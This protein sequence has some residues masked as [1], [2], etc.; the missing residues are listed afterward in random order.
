MEA[1]AL[2]ET[3][4]PVIDLPVNVYGIPWIIGARKGLPNLNKLDVESAFQPRVSY[5]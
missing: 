3:N 5:R 2:A 1:A 4:I